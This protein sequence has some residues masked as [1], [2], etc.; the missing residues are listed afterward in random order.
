MFHS[1]V[2][3]SPPPH[4]ASCSRLARSHATKNEPRIMKEIKEEKR[5]LRSWRNWIADTMFSVLSHG[6]V[7]SGIQLLFFMI[8]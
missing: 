3:Y 7:S 5:Y 6:N 8:Y 2:V 1:L 4:I